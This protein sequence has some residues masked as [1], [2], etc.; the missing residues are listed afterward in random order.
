MID[1]SRDMRRMVE[2]PGSAVQTRNVRGVLPTAAENSFRGH[3]RDADEPASE[4]ADLGAFT[5][6]NPLAASASN[7]R[8]SLPSTEPFPE[9]LSRIDD[10]VMPFADLTVAVGVYLI[11]GI[12]RRETPSGL[13]TAGC[14]HHPRVPGRFRAAAHQAPGQHAHQLC[15]SA[16]RCALFVGVQLMDNSIKAQ[17]SMSRENRFFNPAVFGNAVD[18]ALR[19]CHL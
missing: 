4:S 2:K 16:I 13:G 18:Y 12:P 14:G 7:R 11:H 1:S 19:R 5:G 17:A 10:G 3:P 15:D 9:N 6:T 8:A